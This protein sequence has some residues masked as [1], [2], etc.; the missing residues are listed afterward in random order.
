MNRSVGKQHGN[1]VV[2]KT[3]GED[4][5]N[6][7]GKAKK[8][9]NPSLVLRE[10][11]GKRVSGKWTKSHGEAWET[12]CREDRGRNAMGWSEAGADHHLRPCVNGCRHKQCAQV[13][14]HEQMLREELVL[15]EVRGVVEPDEY[16]DKAS[17]VSAQEKNNDT[18]S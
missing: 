18:I 3:K 7:I 2:E 14:N 11:H 6:P 10:I 17:R 4:G 8:G 12:N 16:V 13:N 1:G 5:M 15:T 9:N